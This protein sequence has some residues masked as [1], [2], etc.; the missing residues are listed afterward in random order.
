[1]S[2]SRTRS[3]DWKLKSA[4]YVPRRQIRM[5]AVLLRDVKGRK[6][7]QIAHHLVKSAGGTLAYASSGVRFLERLR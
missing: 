3:R 1:M 6:G 7:L 5:L 4:D 2:S